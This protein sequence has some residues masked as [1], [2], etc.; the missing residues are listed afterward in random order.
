MQGSGG[1]L[2]TPVPAGLFSLDFPYMFA[3]PR[4]HDGAFVT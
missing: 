2:D 4:R 3:R 1:T